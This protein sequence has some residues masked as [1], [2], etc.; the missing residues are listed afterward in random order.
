MKRQH[1]F[2]I[3]CA[4]ILLVSSCAG[5]GGIRADNLPA[6][7]EDA[8]R[9]QHRIVPGDTIHVTI[10]EVDQPKELN[11]QVKKDGTID[12]MFMKDIK[13]AGLLEDELD[14]YLSKAVSYYYVNP[15][16]SATLTEYVYILGEVKTPGVYGLDKGQTLVAILAVAGGP[17][18]DAKLRNTVIIRGD[19][20]NDP[21]VIVS[22]A[23]KMLR[24]GDI[25][26]N[27]ILQ[28]GDIIYVPSTVISDVNHFITQIVPILDI[29][30]LGA[31]YGL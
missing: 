12:L 28:A 19:Y 8:V 1:I 5:M 14:D 10:W 17:T 26:E 9:Y 16:L 27:V 24:R 11:A 7:P 15:R 22:D 30:L 29:F 21:T 6:A 20:H 4:A 25:S 18:R 23:S 3:L 31:L 2:T 13:V